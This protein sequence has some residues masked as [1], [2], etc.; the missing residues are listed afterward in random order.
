VLVLEDPEAVPVR[1]VGC[2]RQLDVFA[3]RAVLCGSV[4]AGLA[5]VVRE[6]DIGERHLLAFV[7]LNQAAPQRFWT[8][9]CSLARRRCGIGCWRGCG[10]VH[11]LVSLAEASYADFRVVGLTTCDQGGS[12][13]GTTAFAAS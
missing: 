11:R 7:Q 13:R 12:R 6:D 8:P 3:R 5:E 10:F 1:G 9:V 4:Q 2:L